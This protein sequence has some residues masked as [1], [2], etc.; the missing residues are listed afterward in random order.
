MGKKCSSYNIFIRSLHIFHKSCL[1]FFSAFSQLWNDE[2]VSKKLLLLLLA[3]VEG[4]RM[5]I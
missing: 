4:S 3:E 2:Y 1:V 5:E